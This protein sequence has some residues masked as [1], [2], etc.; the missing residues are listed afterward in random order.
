M[1]RFRDIVVNAFCQPGMVTTAARTWPGPG[2]LRLLALLLIAFAPANATPPPA[3][4]SFDFSQLEGRVVVLDFWASW[5]G[6]CKRSFPW[7]NE[8]Q[9]KYKEAGLVVVA[10]NNEANRA[11]AE[12][13]LEQYPADF[14]LIFDPEGELA[15]RFGVKGLPTTFVFDRQGEMVAK[16]LG[17][18]D[19]KRE[20]YERILQQALAEPAEGAPADSRN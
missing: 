3:D 17:F 4:A 14:Q 12:K 16:H 20:W 9:K 10:V 2:A 15:T 8:M 6:P 5:C 11:D 13:F 18:E 1:L 19:A 7:F